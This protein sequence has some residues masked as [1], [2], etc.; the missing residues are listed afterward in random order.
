MCASSPRFRAFPFLLRA[1][2]FP[3][4]PSVAFAGRCRLR[5]PRALAG[6]RTFRRPAPLD[7][8]RVVPCPFEG[9]RR[10]AVGESLCRKCGSGVG[11]ERCPALFL[12]PVRASSHGR[13]GFYALS[14]PPEP[15]FRGSRTA[16]PQPPR[17]R[18]T[19]PVTLRPYRSG[20]VRAMSPCYDGIALALIPYTT[21]AMVISPSDS[22]VYSFPLMMTDG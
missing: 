4:R 8:A 22:S 11:K 21:Q 5:A 12:L 6:A 15:H 20:A 14:G 19:R 1:R 7:S 18:D 16:P 2:R 10:I 17:D 3:A 13:G 9:I